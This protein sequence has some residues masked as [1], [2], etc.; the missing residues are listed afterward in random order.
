LPRRGFLLARFPLFDYGAYVDIA[1][2]IGFLIIVVVFVFAFVRR[3]RVLLFY[4]VFEL[5]L[6]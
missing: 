2:L 6:L 4:L 3:V 5:L 1:L